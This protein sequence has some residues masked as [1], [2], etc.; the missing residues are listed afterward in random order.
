MSSSRVAALRDRSEPVSD[1]RD[2]GVT[3]QRLSHGLSGR[4]VNKWAGRLRLAN[5][6][7]WTNK[8][9]A[10]TA[11]TPDRKIRGVPIA[12]ALLSGGLTL[13]WSGVPALS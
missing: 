13:N 9:I 4:Q 8:N 12:L 3:V 2:D 10:V 6:G 7:E 11:D 1:D 5:K